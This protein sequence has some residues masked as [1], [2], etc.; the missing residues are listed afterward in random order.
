MN[1]ARRAPALRTRVTTIRARRPYQRLDLG[2]ALFAAGLAHYR[3]PV[4]RASI[5]HSVLDIIYVAQ[6]LAAATWTTAANSYGNDEVAPLLM[7][8]L[9]ADTMQALTRAAQRAG[10]ARSATTVLLRSRWRTRVGGRSRDRA[11]VGFI[12]TDPME[13]L[14]AIRRRATGARLV[15]PKPERRMRVESPYICI[16]VARPSS[17]LPTPSAQCPRSCS[18]EWVARFPRA[19]C[20][21]LQGCARRLHVRRQWHAANPSRS[22]NHG[23]VVHAGNRDR[24]SAR[25]ERSQLQ[26]DRLAHV[27]TTA[28][29]PKVLANL[30]SVDSA[31]AVVM[32]AIDLQ[33]LTHA[34]SRGRRP[35][36]KLFRDGA[37]SCRS[38]SCRALVCE[39]FA[40]L[41]PGAKPIRRTKSSAAFVRARRRPNARGAHLHASYASRI[42]T[43][44]AIARR[45]PAGHEAL[46]ARNSGR[47]CC[48]IADPQFD[49][50]FAVRRARPGRRGR[51]TQ[52]CSPELA[53]SR[54]ISRESRRVAY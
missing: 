24:H 11:R 53:S 52:V 15:H 26:P 28:A 6:S 12:S 16:A 20:R 41:L 40:L 35:A 44:R 36:L 46:F 8:N 23:V 9:L 45:D 38:R 7:I 14:L 19:A 5:S 2:G 30:M 27:L 1:S 50:S 17:D 51:I 3:V 25:F 47:D 49:G 43:W 48:T 33:A 34:G 10:A 21:E 13:T 29:P 31:F 18:G 4:H 37:V 54:R 32:T 39:D 42:R 22:R